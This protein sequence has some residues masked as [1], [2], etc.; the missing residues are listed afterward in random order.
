MLGNTYGITIRRG[1]LYQSERDDV[2]VWQQSPLPHGIVLPVKVS[3]DKSVASQSK[4][5]QRYQTKQQHRWTQPAEVNHVL[6]HM[7]RISFNDKQPQRSS[8]ATR[9]ECVSDQM[10]CLQCTGQAIIPGRADHPL[11][12]CQAGESSSQQ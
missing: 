11:G 7:P 8:K 6:H 1:T 4:L 3:R 12:R 2:P 5:L 9:H 10:G